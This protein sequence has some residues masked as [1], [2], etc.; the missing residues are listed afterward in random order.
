MEP[1]KI[2]KN[3]VM[4]GLTPENIV[5]KYAGNNPMFKN[6]IEMQKQG[7]IEGIETF[8]RNLYKQKGRDFDEEYAKMRN[9]LK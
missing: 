8:A 3:F 9:I 4:Q 7:N 1:Y 2:I 6:L 5:M